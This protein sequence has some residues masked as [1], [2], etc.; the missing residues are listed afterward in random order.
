M[1]TNYLSPTSFQ[2]SVGRIP[3]VEFFVQR[4]NIPALTGNPVEL[5][6]PLQSYY[7]HQDRISYSD[8][9]LSFVVDENMD[10]YLEI[11]KWMEGLGSPRESDQYKDLVGPEGDGAVSDITVIIHN[12]NKRPSIR[13]QLKN[14]FPVSISSVPL[15]IV[16]ADIVYPEVTVTFR[17][18]DFTIEKI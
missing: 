16:S 2:V 9:D 17:Y 11:A 12:S 13:M 4:A 3:N 7:S 10:N 15:N 8:F 6:S 1:Q 14:C 18:D 5:S